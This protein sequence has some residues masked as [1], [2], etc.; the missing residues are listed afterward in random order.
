MKNDTASFRFSS[1]Q[2]LAAL[3]FILFELHAKAAGATPLKVFILAGQSNM[4]G[5]VNVSTFD[6]MATDPR[7]APILAEM[8]NADGSPRVCDRV[9]ISSIGCAGNDTTEQKGKLTVGFGASRQNIG[10]EFTFGIYIEKLLKE[11]VLIIKTSWGGKSLHTDFRPPSAGP[12]AWSDF[13]LSQCKKRGDDLEKDK[14]EKIKATGV[15]YR[16]MIEHVH[17][18]LGDIK[19]VVPDYDEKQGYEVAGFVWFQGFNDLVSSWTYEKHNQPDQYEMY[20][21]L[22]ADFIRDV[23]K[24]LNAPKMPFVIGV[25]G[26]NGATPPQNE[27]HF[28]KGPSRPGIASRVCG[29]CGGGGNRALLG[30]RLRRDAETC[31]GSLAQGRRFIG[32]GKQEASAPDPGWRGVQEQIHRRQPSSEHRAAHE[33]CFQLWIP[34]PW[35]R[36]NHRANRQGICGI[37]GQA[38]GTG[39][40]H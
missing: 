34:L 6:Y 13:E 32:R 10:P 7:T 31:S 39:R 3:L 11:P 16:L 29:K 22:L 24:D 21:E 40:C 19:R 4:Q 33:R 38:R 5:H 36:E 12:F 18:V 25:M 37:D 2:I 8:R 15:Y 23:R 1:F 14:V 30:P 17:K 35:R 26:L 27:T 28:H 9:W 20:S